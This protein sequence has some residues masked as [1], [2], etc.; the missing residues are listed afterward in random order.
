[1][2]ENTVEGKF[3]QA[4]GEVKQN[5]GDVLG[6]ED[7]KAEGTWDKVKGAVKEGAGK[8]QDALDGDN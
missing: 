4:K 8:V 5:V 3:D 2:N 7:I 1:M 6:D